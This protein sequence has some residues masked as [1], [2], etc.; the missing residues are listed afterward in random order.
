MKQMI[1]DVDNNIIVDSKTLHKN[2]T[3]AKEIMTSSPV[4]IAKQSNSI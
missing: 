2:L 3:L 4:E 1:Y